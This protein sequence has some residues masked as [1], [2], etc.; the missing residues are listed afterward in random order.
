MTSPFNSTVAYA[1][2]A[3][4]PETVYAAVER[5]IERLW[6]GMSELV[7][8]DPPRLLLHRVGSEHDDVGAWLTWELAPTGPSGSWTQLRLLHD[9]LD[10]S[11]GPPPE[12]DQVL[13]LLV[14]SLGAARASQ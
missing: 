6:S 14:E 5:L 10:T 13:S 8:A 3:G 4:T 11:A 12:L 2:I 9:E 7:L 1:S